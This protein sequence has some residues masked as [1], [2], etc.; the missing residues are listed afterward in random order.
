L[1]AGGGKLGPSS[2]GD[3]R[4]NPATPTTAPSSSSAATN[5]S[6][7]GNTTQASGGN[8]L[9]ETPSA[10]QTLGG[11]SQSSNNPNTARTPTSATT[12]TE[13]TNAAPNVSSLPSMIEMLSYDQQLKLRVLGAQNGAAFNSAFAIEQITAHESAIRN[14]RFA[15]QKLSTPQ[16][17][18]FAQ[19][20]LAVLEKN[21]R[22]ARALPR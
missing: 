9:S 1:Y 22:S 3:N 5:S 16:M 6:G 12:R 11:G 14:V 18:T 4:P 15:A 20:T 8:A 10:E 2:S 17:K 7:G 13:G 19:Q 21:L